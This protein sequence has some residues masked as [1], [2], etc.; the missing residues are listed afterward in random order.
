MLRQ[1]RLRPAQAIQFACHAAASAPFVVVCIYEMARG[2]APQGDDGVIV[3]RSWLV[4]TQ[5][6]PLLGQRTEVITPHTIY[7]LGPLLYWLLTIP[8]HIDH[9]QGGLWGAE[10]FCVVAVNLAVGAAWAVMGWRAGIGAVVVLLATIA[11]VPALVID[12][13]WNPH[14]GLVWFLAT[15]AIAWAVAAGRLGWWPALVVAASISTQS[16][17][18]FA[19]GSI[20][21]VVIAPLVG[22][23]GNRWVGWW[24]WAGLTSGLL[25]WLAPLVEQVT[26]HPGNM[27]LVL[28]L[29]HRSGPHEGLAFGLSS[30]AAVVGPSPVWWGRGGSSDIGIFALMSDIHA[31]PPWAGVLVLGGVGCCAVLSWSS[32]RRALGALALVALVWALSAVWTSAELPMSQTLS[33]IYIEP[34]SWPLGITILLV[35]FWAIADIVLAVV[36]RL[37]PTRAKRSISERFR[38]LAPIVVVGLAAVAAASSGLAV[39]ESSTDDITTS[40]WPAMSQVRVAAARIERSVPRGPL[41]VISSRIFNASYSIIPGLD[42]LLYADGWRPES[43]PGYTTLIGPEIAPRKPPP[44]YTALITYDGGPARITILKRSRPCGSCQNVGSRVPGRPRP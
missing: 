24:L 21:L 1:A 38:R 13:V 27:S 42:W 40:G 22:L 35:G 16:H 7:D 3:F 29:P 6:S 19:I 26:S 17:L 9:V 23:L 36:T 11:E 20:G 10:L 5:Q 8:V 30:L 39:H 34:S 44:V 4:L 37:H 25:C 32:R 28:E 2:W 31:H 33:Y 12:P 18:M 14:F 43:Y 15:A 41:T